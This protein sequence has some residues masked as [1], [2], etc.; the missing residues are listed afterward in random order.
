MRE[1]WF[2]K[3]Y[4]SVHFFHGKAS[5]M[6]STIMRY[7]Q[8]KF[9]GKNREVS[10]NT[11]EYWYCCWLTSYGRVNGIFLSMTGSHQLCYLPAPKQSFFCC[12]HSVWNYQ[13]KFHYL[14]Q[15]SNYVASWW[16]ALLALFLC[17]TRH[18]VIFQTHV[19]AFKALCLTAAEK[20]LEEKK[21]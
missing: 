18:K 15:Q 19:I 3:K 1:F 9:Y 4:I 6:T 14:Q 21:A 13:K 10:S 16:L 12:W 20:T 8:K 17:K 7:F 2:W 11:T 5:Q